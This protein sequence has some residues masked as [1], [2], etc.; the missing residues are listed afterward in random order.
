VVPIRIW[1]LPA[2][3]FKVKPSVP[4][5][6]A[7]CRIRYARHRGGNA[8]GPLSL[9]EPPDR[10]QNTG[11]ATLYVTA[12]PSLTGLSWRIRISMRLLSMSSTFSWH[13]SSR[14]SGRVF[15]GR[16]WNLLEFNASLLR[17]EP[18][19]T[20]RNWFPAMPIIYGTDACRSERHPARA[21]RECSAEMM[22]ECV[23][24]CPDVY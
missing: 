16:F 24:G 15:P 19:P 20:Y 12:H 14:R 5:S 1:L 7:H 8:H 10:S 13:T 9:G 3:P 2:F 4:G 18:K 21:A 22:F 6:G 23:S 17:H 11:S